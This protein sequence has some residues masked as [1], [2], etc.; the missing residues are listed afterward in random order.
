M[1]SVKAGGEVHVR[2]LEDMYERLVVI[3]EF[4]SQ[5]VATMAALLLE[6]SIAGEF[7][8]FTVVAEKVKRLGQT[9]SERE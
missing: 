8:A 7:H 5:P 2:L 1:R 4:N 6:K 9:G 3:A